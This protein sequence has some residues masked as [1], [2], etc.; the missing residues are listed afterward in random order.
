MIEIAL[1]LL[2]IAGIALNAIVYHKLSKAIQL[3]KHEATRNSDNVITQIEALFAIYAEVRPTRALPKSRR[4]AA[5]PDM[6]A[7]MI[8][9]TQKHFPKQI[10]ECSSGYSTVVLA[11]CLRNLGNGHLWSL[12][13]ERHYAEETRALLGVHGLTKWATVV[14]SPLIPYELTDWQGKWYDVSALTKPL[15]IDLLAI[16]GPPDELGRLARYPALPALYNRL[17]PKGIVLLD[18]SNRVSERESLARWLLEFP[19][20]ELVPQPTCEKG[21]VVLQRKE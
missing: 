17:A 6:L 2:V 10:V 15:A 14:D 1:G 19:S 21:C 5:S 16:D 11:A 12:E 3:A 13:H 8:Y 7:L 20:L 9:Q 4:W 18:D